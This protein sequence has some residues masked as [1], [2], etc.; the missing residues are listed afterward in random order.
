MGYNVMTARLRGGGSASEWQTD[1][2]GTTD[3]D[4]TRLSIGNIDWESGM[5]GT[6][7]SHGWVS[8]HCL[9]SHGWVRPCLEH[10]TSPRRD[11][12][13]DEADNDDDDIPN[14]M[15]AYLSTLLSQGGKSVAAQW[16]AGCAWDEVRLAAGLKLEGGSLPG[17]AAKYPGTYRLVVGKLVNGRPAYQ[18]VTDTTLWIAFDGDS[19]MGQIESSLGKLSL[20]HI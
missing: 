12:T 11:W 15:E 5:P 6:P 7:D 13:G 10:Q 14:P 2:G 3:D 17:E 19:W 20:I 16:T 18:H 1:D 9:E 4:G 8:R